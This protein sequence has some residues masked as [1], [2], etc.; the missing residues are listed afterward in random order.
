MTGT[1]VDPPSTAATTCPHCAEPVSAYEAFCENCGRELSPTQEAPERL[2]ADTPVS[3]SRSVR[4]HDRHE[5]EQVAPG[6]T[7]CQECGGVVGVDG[8]CEQ[9]GTLAPR[10]RDHFSEAPADWVAGTCDRGIRHHRNEDAVALSADRSGDRAVL[11]VCDGVSTSD[12]SDV[13]SLAGARAARDLLTS[14]RPAGVGTPEARRLAQLQ[15]LVDAVATANEVV[16]AATDPASTNVASCTLSAAVVDRGFVSWANIGD[17]RVYWIADPPDAGSAVRRVGGSAQLSVDDSVAQARIAMGVAREDA[18]NG[19]GAHAITKWLG[20]DAPDLAPD[21]GTMK[22]PGPG[23]LL[24]C[25][26][27]L[28]NYASDAS[29]LEALVADLLTRS[30]GTPGRSTTLA[31]SE[32]L[33]R[34]ACEQGGKDNV[35]AALA[36]FGALPDTAGSVRHNEVADRPT[37]DT[38]QGRPGPGGA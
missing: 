10:P 3:L 8:Y 21:T 27:G 31:L 16:V 28:W 25:S 11:V 9:C 4:V 35:T 19:P 18:E 37:T 14:T 12:D 38:A 15:A 23:W 2:V 6:R 24:V 5:P 29:A 22:V 13:A 30:G 36:R 32:A 7:P 1:P 34:W 33:C 26:D 17:S 20:R